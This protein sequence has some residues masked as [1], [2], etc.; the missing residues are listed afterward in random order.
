MDATIVLAEYLQEYHTNCNIL[1]D[2]A[3]PGRVLVYGGFGN[4][5]EATTLAQIYP[6]NIISPIFLKRAVAR[7]EVLI[8]KFKRKGEYVRE[9]DPFTYFSKRWLNCGTHYIY[10]NDPNSLNELSNILRNW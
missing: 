3:I 7:D 1:K 8:R 2:I 5:G 10:L 6:S 9:D 4:N